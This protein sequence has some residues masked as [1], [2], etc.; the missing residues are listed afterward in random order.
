MQRLTLDRLAP[1]ALL[2]LGTV[3]G[4]AGTDLVLPAIPALARDLGGTPAEAQ[5][6][7][8]AFTAGAAA[9]LLLFGALGAQQDWRRLLMV[10]ATSFAAVSLV[11]ACVDSIWLLIGLRFFQGACGAAAAVFAPAVIR[12]LFHGPQAVR[13]LAAF[14][15]IEAMA[16]AL[17]PLAGAALLARWDWRASFVVLA[18]LGAL[19]A[20]AL[21]WQ[22]GRLPERLQLAADGSYVRL[23]RNRCFVRLA[24][25]HAFSLAALL[26]IVFAAPAVFSRLSDAPVRAFVTM[27]MVGITAFVLVANGAGL[28]IERFGALQLLR[29]GSLLS[30]VSSAAIFGAALLGTGQTPVITVLFVLLCTGFG[31]RAPIGFYAALTSAQGDDTRAAACI[32]VAMLLT[33]ALG[34]AVV[35][36]FVDSGMAAPAAVAWLLACT[37]AVLGWRTAAPP[38]AGRA[39]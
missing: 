14:G 1:F 22:A 37:A 30:A 29:L 3:L 6:V 11:A 26:V 15:S 38:A 27:Q 32:V 28:V 21:R 34:T 35:A 4:L 36:P 24:L 8:A 19:L 18:A 5:W 12:A 9:G 2:V 10:S 16:P 20:L 7:L 39:A 13:A 23:A 31:F 33:T 25:S 17:A